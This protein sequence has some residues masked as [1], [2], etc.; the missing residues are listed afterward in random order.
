ME[1]VNRYIYAVT[2]GL[3]QKQRGD[4]EKELKTLIEDMLEQYQ[5]NEPYETKVEKVLLELGDPAVLAE[6]YRESKRYLIGPGNYDNYI[7]TLKIVL[8]AVF[9]GISVAI[10]VGSIFSEQQNAAGIF[11]DYITTLFSGLLQGFAWVTAVFTVAERRGINLTAHG[12][13]TGEVWSIAK[14]PEIPEKEAVISPVETIF[15]ILV[16]VLFITVLYLSPQIFG[17][18]IADNITGTRIIPIF[19]T[20]VIKGYR[21][22]LA[23]ILVFSIAKGVIMLI[24][25]RW[26]FKAASVYS[27]L[28]IVSTAI[29]LAFFSDARIWN[30]DFSAELFKHVEISIGFINR[31]GQTNIGILVIVAAAGLLD[32]ATVM[33]KGIKYNYN[34]RI[35]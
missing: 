19:D 18:Y 15:T 10:G 34:S 9:L 22:M 4:I 23:G 1:L 17:V 24:S 7:L 20:A 29:S 35:R 11:K 14:L 25:G 2:K 8:G 26:T 21:L 16:T 3:P 32:V 5:E 12:G 33:Y 31:H 30:P 28:S 6:N 27:V 13:T